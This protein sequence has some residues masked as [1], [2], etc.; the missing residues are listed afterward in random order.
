MHLPRYARSLITVLEPGDPGMW[1]RPSPDGTTRT[2]VSTQA[3]HSLS[4]MLICHQGSPRA[5]DRGAGT[6]PPMVTST[7]DFWFTYN[8]VEAALP[9]TSFHWFYSDCTFWQLLFE[10]LKR[11]QK[12]TSNYG[13]NIIF[14]TINDFWKLSKKFKKDEFWD[15]YT[16]V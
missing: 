16:N 9:L 3:H 7:W 11:F 4:H 6:T 15:I 1:P 8:Q 5:G 12:E 14:L 2:T 13:V 10:Y